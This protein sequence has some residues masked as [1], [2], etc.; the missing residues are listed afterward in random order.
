MNTHSQQII[1]AQRIN[2]IIWISSL[3]IL[4]ISSFVFLNN[5]ME[6]FENLIQETRMEFKPVITKTQEVLDRSK[7]GIDSIS[8]SGK[9]LLSSVNPRNLLDPANENERSK[10]V[11]VEIEKSWNRLNQ[12]YINTRK[13]LDNEYRQFKMDAG[14]E[15]SDFKNDY[16]QFKEDLKTVKKDIMQEITNWRI[17]ITFFLSLFSILMLIISIK[18]IMENARWFI[19]FF[20]SIL[21]KDKTIKT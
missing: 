15:Y 14:K 5:M 6:R 3:F 11:V 13:N 7:T 4:V 1:H 17:M 10:N 21:K 9:D 12:D 19:T 18:D 20:K 8:A 2:T 16:R